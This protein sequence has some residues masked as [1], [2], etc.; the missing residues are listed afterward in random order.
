M[1]IRERL[2]G[3]E[4]VAYAIRQINPDVMPAFPITPS[5]EIPQYV[6]NY[7]ANGKVDTEFIHVES[8]H[9]AMS[10]AIGACAAGAR[11]VTA[12]SSCGMAL[13]WEELYVAAS[14]R[15][16]I[17]LALV[18]RALS[19]PIN[20]NADHSDSMGARDT[21]WIQIYAESNQEVYDNFLQAYPIAEHEA[22]HLPVMICQDGFIT[23]H[24]V[25]NILLA[26]DDRVKEFVGEYC[27]A[28]YL[29][30]EKEPMALGPYAVSNYYMETKR[31]Q[32]EAM[33]NARQVI[34][35]VAER[36]EKMTG[37]KYGFFEEYRMEDAEYVI[38]IIGSAAGTCRAAVDRIR[39]VSGK[40][41]GLLKIRVFR[42]FPEKELAEAL[43]DKKAVAVLDRSEM[44]SATGGPL[45]TEVR[46]ALYGVKS[47]AEVVNY[48]YGLG[49]RDITVEDFEEVYAK[50]E[51]LAQTRVVKDMYAYI[52][53]REK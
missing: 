38:V 13:M 5:T 18:N 33:E 10:A 40:K 37:R 41:A 6:A 39:E 16:P 7:I 4:A 46:S 43:K 53:L 22:V 11:A 23:S 35:E 14:D 52:G 29:L 47:Q 1:A 34:L 8:E 17:V 27:P 19:G 48:F 50:L 42:P 20:I 3:N 26:E 45:G 12:T 2:S 49:G 36:F 44:F 51:E 28:H 30:N 32:R 15:L 31:G 24:G 25:E 21:G 9:S